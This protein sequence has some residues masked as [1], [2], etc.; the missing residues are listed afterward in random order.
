MSEE[1]TEADFG[2]KPF[3]R[4]SAS[5]INSFLDYKP[6][7]AMERLFGVK[8]YEES[9][10]TAR[11]KAVEEGLNHYIRGV[12]NLVDEKGNPTGNK[13]ITE[14]CGYA[15]EQFREMVKDVK[16]D[17][18]LEYTQTITPCVEGSCLYFSEHY[19]IRN[20]GMQDSFEIEMEG[21][22][23]PLVGYLD[24]KCR[25]NKIIIDKKVK[26]KTP[27]N[28]TIPQGYVVQGA[29]YRY[30]T[31]IKH[32]EFNF[33]IPL[34]T[35]PNKVLAIKLS[36]AEYEWG[37]NLARKAMKAIELTHEAAQGMDMDTLKAF[38]MPSPDSFWDADKRKTAMD[39]FTF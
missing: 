36:D 31:G 21:C 26:A 15:V 7:W 2:I 28:N 22:K 5:Q 6:E 19:P 12:Q 23:Y 8:K 35:Q 25:D 27:T 18:K 32:I 34:K 24:Y 4:H 10:D 39:F 13:N 20:L 9:V 16:S 37:L 29:L 14:C 30:A 1:F 11:G 17:K 3:K 38:F 33:S